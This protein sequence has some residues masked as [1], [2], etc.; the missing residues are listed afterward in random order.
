MLPNL[1][2]LA[3]DGIE[4]VSEPSV[5]GLWQILAVLGIVVVLVAYKIYKNKTMT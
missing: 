4:E 5:F 3:Q 1:L 2:M